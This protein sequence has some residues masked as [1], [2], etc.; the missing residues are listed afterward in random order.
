MAVE[1]W[2]RLW[3]D[4]DFGLQRETVFFFK[5]LL[6]CGYNQVTAIA[7]CCHCLL[8]WVLI[9]CSYIFGMLFVSVLWLTSLTMCA[10]YKIYFFFFIILKI[11]CVVFSLIYNC[12]LRS[13]TIVYLLGCCRIVPQIYSLQF[14]FYLSNH[15]MCH[16]Y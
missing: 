16:F 8:D 1:K 11:D 14:I 3:N 5:V 13:Y 4:V 2:I 6:C 12:T 9:M 10:I 15:Q 7:V